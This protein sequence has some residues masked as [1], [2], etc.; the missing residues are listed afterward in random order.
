MV[1]LVWSWYCSCDVVCDE[2]KRELI[3]RSLYIYTSPSNY[4]VPEVA[5]VAVSQVRP[6]GNRRS[7]G[8][9]RELVAL[10]S[11]R[12]AST[13]R[14]NISWESW[15]GRQSTHAVCRR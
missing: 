2:V 1:D 9:T 14:L 5:A 4:R 15:L 6:T 3:T 13:H 8:P 11:K 10:R 7:R 12:R